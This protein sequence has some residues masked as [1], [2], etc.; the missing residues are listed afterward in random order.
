MK[1]SIKKATTSV[2]MFF[3]GRFSSKKNRAIH[4]AR[5]RGNAHGNIRSANS[6]SSHTASKSGTGSVVRTTTP[7]KS[8]RYAAKKINKKRFTVVVAGIL[9]AIMI[10]VIV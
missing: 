3:S 10:P 6:V 7:P 5:V 9:A 8:R 4:N 2:K 1:K